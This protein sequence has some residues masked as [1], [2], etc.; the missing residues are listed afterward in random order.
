MEPGALRFGGV[1]EG[2]D[3]GA[4]GAVAWRVA[5][6]AASK[7]GAEGIGSAGA[8]SGTMAC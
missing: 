5:E 1:A 7:S 2:R 3:E 6:A 8:G 4:A